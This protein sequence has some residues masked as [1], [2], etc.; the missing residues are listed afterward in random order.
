MRVCPLACRGGRADGGTR[1]GAA[2]SAFGARSS[3]R[4][5]HSVPRGSGRSR[6]HPVAQRSQ[7]LASPRRADCGWIGPARG[8]LRGLRLPGARVRPGMVWPAGADGGSRG[9]LGIPEPPGS[10][11]A[12]LDAGGWFRVVGPKRPYP[13]EAVLL[14][15][16]WASERIA[17]RRVQGCRLGGRPRWRPAARPLGGGGA[18]SAAGAG[19][20]G[21]ALGVGRDPAGSCG[22]LAG[23]ADGL[24][25]GASS[26]FAALAAS[27]VSQ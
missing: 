11:A 10:R 26:A 20:D 22:F 3:L 19:C 7:R 8:V 27:T 24:S 15:G 4:F 6:R 13:P 25:A 18:Q 14:F 1:T 12:T 9:R 21:V 5:F 23:T 17:A 2:V 16:R